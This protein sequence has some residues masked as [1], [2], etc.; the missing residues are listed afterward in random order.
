[1]KAA[2]GGSS[3]SF[4]GDLAAAATSIA[5]AFVADAVAALLFAEVSMN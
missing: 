2:G 3:Y 4:G 1:V 5:V